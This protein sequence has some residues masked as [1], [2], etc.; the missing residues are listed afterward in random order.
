MVTAT[1]TAK[2]LAD[3]LKK[4]NV[5][6]VAKASEVCTKTI[7]RLRR[8]QNSPTLGTVQKILSGIAQVRASRA[9]E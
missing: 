2:E 5:I 9:P 7:Y 1:V 4:V 8:Q 3:L 6:E